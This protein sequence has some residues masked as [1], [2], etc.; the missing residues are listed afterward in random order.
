MSA[1][2]MEMI[3]AVP[4]DGGYLVIDGVSDL[5]PFSYA[6]IGKEPGT[7]A[8]VSVELPRLTK[9][10]AI[11]SLNRWMTS[12]NKTEKMSLLDKSKKLLNELFDPSS[13]TMNPA[14]DVIQLI[15]TSRI[16]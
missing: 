10:E 3:V 16:Q 13:C 2:T 8:T 7:H 1:E 9:P 11:Q 12:S 14:G 4:V 6:S 15:I 5:I